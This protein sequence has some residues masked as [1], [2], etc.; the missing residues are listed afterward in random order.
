MVSSATSSRDWHQRAINVSPGGVHGA[1][2]FYE[3]F[4]LFM[5]QAEGP[6]IWDV[7][8]NRYIDLHAGFGTSALGYNDQDVRRAVSEVMETEGVLYGAPHPREVLLSER[9]T[10][11]I[12]CADKV[13]LCGGG[14]SDPLLFAYRAAC[15][16]TGRRKFLKFEGE[17]HGWNDPF[18]VS[19]RPNLAAAGPPDRPQPVFATSDPGSRDTAVVGRLNDVDG[20]Q[21]IFN[22]HGRELACVFIEPVCHTS[23]CIELDDEFLSELRA[24]CDSTGTLLVFDEVLTGF[25]HSIHGAQKL[26]GVV[27][28]LAAFGKALANGYQISVLAGQNE[29]MDELTPLGDVFYSGTFCGHLLGVAAADATLDQLEDSEVRARLAASGEEVAKAI[30]RTAEEQDVTMTCSSFGSVFTPYFTAQDVKEYRDIVGVSEHQTLAKAYRE[31]LLSAGIFLHPYFVAR[32]FIGAAHENEHIAKII[33]VSAAFVTEFKEDI[34][35]ATA[36]E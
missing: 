2:R 33:D 27:P 30:R 14:G 5:N 13:A 12:P 23:G 10:G 6:Y 19:V 17:Y 28:D 32:C 4:P 31:Y 34:N 29:V 15:T 25:R 26:V 9:L 20:L 21:R 16:R 36:H 18:V 11:L 7:D 1:A 24:L 22:E 3:P 35:K 8:G